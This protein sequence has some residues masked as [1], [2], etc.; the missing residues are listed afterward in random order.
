MFNLNQLHFRE[1]IP[2]KI[3]LENTNRKIKGRDGKPDIDL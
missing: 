1:N 3:C 2:N